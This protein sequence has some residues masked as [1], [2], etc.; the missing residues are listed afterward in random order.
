MAL[1]QN[2][3]KI[4]KYLSSKYAF[5]AKGG[6]TKK[7]MINLTATN[8]PASLISAPNGQALPTHLAFD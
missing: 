1:K 8:T 2:N 5:T 4:V 3:A 7:T 6:K